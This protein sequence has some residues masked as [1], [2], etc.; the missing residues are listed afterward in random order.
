MS[1]LRDLGVAVGRL[2][3]GMEN[4]ITDVEGVMVGHAEVGERGLRSGITAVLPYPPEVERRRLCVGRWSLDGGDGLT[5]LGV[6]EDFGTFSSPIVLAPAA[7]VGAVYDALIQHGLGRDSGLST[8]A[9]WPP[10]VV[11]VDDGLWNPARV[12][13]QV[14][15]EEYLTRALSA[16]AAGPVAEGNAGIGQGL[17]AFGMKGGVG[18]ASRLVEWRG[19][20]YTVGALVAANGGQRGEL[21][22]DGYPAAPLVRVDVPH[23]R[24]PD[25]FAGVAA[26]DAP[27]LPGQLDR[28]AGRAALGLSRVGLLTPAARSGLMLAF[29]TTAIVRERE[30]EEAVE[31]MRSGGEELLYALSA[32]VAEAGEEAV[33]NGLLGAAPVDGMTPVLEVLSGE[34]WP[35]AV[36]RFQ[37]ERGEREREGKGVEE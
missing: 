31:G 27:L 15:R 29:S 30:G 36:R 5:G 3:A 28:L 34:G 32:A 25:S 4:A 20:I 26:T 9:G 18:T 6:A 1:R 12:V 2:P 13:H 16:A 37:A 11:G 33:L 22:V 14:V 35:A 10:V 7:A 8:V 24:L 19:T 21:R 23:R 17:C